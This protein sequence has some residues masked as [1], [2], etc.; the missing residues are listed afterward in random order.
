MDNIYLIGNAGA[1]AIRR[2][3]SERDPIFVINDFQARLNLHYKS[4]DINTIY[5]LL[6]IS[7][8]SRFEIHNGILYG[9]QREIIK[10]IDSENWSKEK[11]NNFLKKNL[12]LRHIPSIYG[13]IIAL[14]Q[15][16]P[17][18]QTESFYQ[19]IGHDKNFIDH[20]PLDIR[21]G[22][23]RR[24]PNMIIDLIAH[25]ASNYQNDSILRGW[26]REMRGVNINEYLDAR[27]NQEHVQE[28]V[29]II[30]DD[31][32]LF[33][34]VQPIFRELFV[35]FGWASICSFRT[36]FFMAM[37][38]AGKIMMCKT[39]NSYEL[40]WFV[41]E[42]LRK[43]F[44]PERVININN[45]IHK[46]KGS[47]DFGEMAMIFQDPIVSNVLAARIVQALRKTVQEK[48]MIESKLDRSIIWC[49][50]LLNLGSHA[51]QMLSTKSYNMP[52]MDDEIFNEFY[53]KILSLMV[54]DKP[55]TSPAVA[56]QR[57]RQN[58]VSG[59]GIESL[60]PSD[61]YNPPSTNESR[62]SFFSDK[63][64]EK[65]KTNDLARKVFAH[66][67]IDTVRRMEFVS[68]R[69]AVSYMTRTIPQNDQDIMY[70]E[71]YES[72]WQSLITNL[73]KYHR[74]KLIV[75][76]VWSKFM[77]EEL[78]PITS[79]KQTV[80][81]MMA[82]LL[83]ELYAEEIITSL[84]ERKCPER[85]KIVRVWAE[86]TIKIGAKD[87]DPT[88]LMKMYLELRIKSKNPYDGRFQINTEE[89]PT[90]SKFIE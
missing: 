75:N 87:M 46:F 57:R 12:P 10:R 49:S 29:K 23:Y 31:P 71:V 78:I 43:G 1:E 88:N 59:S 41:T 16:Y 72:L 64:I 33:K 21:R 45:Y 17:E 81:E 48:N 24:Y 51:R 2:E 61:R 44:T 55:R 3:L 84:N 38:N 13:L 53:F 34:S 47:S 25:L 42:S 90:I 27:V 73:I 63:E 50:H 79:W 83:V 69:R 77:D 62:L 82:K 52:E 14:L 36:D 65:L 7:G 67:L 19:E 15:R 35:Q 9:L 5:P 26:S 28:A 60:D 22:F 76:P 37:Q 58:S 8:N 4:F 18:L 56:A 32:I 80:H 30:G 86:K 68:V 6:E 74:I 20:S 89:C 85:I 54:D 11:R 40:I 39:D 70:S 66:Y